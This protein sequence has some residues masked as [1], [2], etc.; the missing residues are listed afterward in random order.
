M[1]TQ[2]REDR[3]TPATKICRRG[4]WSWQ[5]MNSTERAGAG[6]FPNP[7]HLARHVCTV[8]NGRT[9][10]LLPILW[11]ALAWVATKFLQSDHHNGQLV[12]PV[13]ITDRRGSPPDLAGCRA[14]LGTQ[15][16]PRSSIPHIPY[17]SGLARLH[18]PLP[19]F[20]A[21]RYGGLRAER[22]DGKRD[23]YFQHAA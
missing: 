5:R 21:V 23:L 18:P 9:A 17:P 1:S 4:R 8:A 19:Q 20:P 15:A 13:L 11:S 2:K 7:A 6:S 16:T 3:S 22:Y 12:R 14:P 10:S